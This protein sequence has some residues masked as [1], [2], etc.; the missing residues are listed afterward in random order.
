MHSPGNGRLRNCYGETC[1]NPQVGCEV[2]DSVSQRMLWTWPGTASDGFSTKFDRDVY[3]RLSH[4]AY[5]QSVSIT[6]SGP[7]AHMSDSS[8]RHEHGY[9]LQLYGICKHQPIEDQPGLDGIEAARIV[10][11]SDLGA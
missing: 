3:G 2:T 8:I 9:S 7:N 5:T 10:P 1:C 6:C 11:F 4:A